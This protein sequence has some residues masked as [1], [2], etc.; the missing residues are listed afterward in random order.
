[1]DLNEIS[2]LK[3][4]LLLL[5]IGDGSE[6]DELNQKFGSNEKIFFTGGIEDESELALYMDCVDFFIHTGLVGLNLVH[7]MCYGKPSLVLDLPIHS[8]E[9]EY[10]I[11]GENGLLLNNVNELKEVIL[12]LLGDKEEVIRLGDNAL[13]SIKMNY[14]IKSMS[15]NFLKV[16][17]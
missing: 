15:N 7:G 2:I 6:F 3:N 5:I 4:D 10:L 8:P 16:L 9:I 14:N 13:R 17:N 1:M 12:K 11:N